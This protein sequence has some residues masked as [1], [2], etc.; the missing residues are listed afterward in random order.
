MVHC[1][2]STSK[3]R[4]PL[5][6]RMFHGIF[7]SFVNFRGNFRFRENFR[8]SFRENFRYFRKLSSRKAK[9]FFRENMKTKIFVST[10]P[11]PQLNLLAG[12]WRS[13]FFIAMRMPNPC[14]TFAAC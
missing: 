11:G 13:S 6:I 1:I 3:L 4:L 14:P 5:G 2:P 7:A 8:Q 9:N 12:V 10:L